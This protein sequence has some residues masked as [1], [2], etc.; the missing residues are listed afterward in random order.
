MDC[1]NFIYKDDLLSSLGCI[2]RCHWPIVLLIDTSSSMSEKIN[3]LN[4]ELQLLKEILINNHPLTNNLISIVEMGDS[5]AKIVQDF[6]PVY[7]WQVK[8]YTARGC[9]PIKQAFELA[10]KQIQKIKTSYKADGESYYVPVLVVFTDGILINYGGNADVQW[11]KIVD[12][13]KQFTC[14]FQFSCVTIYIGNNKSEDEAKFEIIKK[15]KENLLSISSTIH[16]KKSFINMFE[17]NGKLMEIL[18]RL[19]F[20]KE[21]FAISPNNNYSSPPIELINRS[22]FYE[23]EDWDKLRPNYLVDKGK[24]LIIPTSIFD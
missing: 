4:K 12:K 9:K 10:I 19:Y 15:A 5:K 7:S 21:S 17:D 14:E 24:Q 16:D 11:K 1:D 2:R 18:H 20:K 13:I 23:D 3:E 6:I 8:K 22:I